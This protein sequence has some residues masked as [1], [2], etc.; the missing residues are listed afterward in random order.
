MSAPIIPFAPGADKFIPAALDSLNAD[1]PTKAA[2][3]DVLTQVL[4]QEIPREQAATRLESLIGTSTLLRDLQQ[5][6]KSEMAIH[7][8]L[9][10]EI[11]VPGFRKQ[12][13]KWCKEEDHKL[14]AAVQQHGTD[15]WPLIASIVGGGRTRSQCSQRW[16]RGIDPKLTK[17][18][19]SREEEERL[20]AAVDAH[21]SKAWTRIAA[22]MGNRSDVQCRFR[23]RFLC[24]K[25]KEANGP[26]QPISPPM[27]VAHLMPEVI[28]IP[29]N[30]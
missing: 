9:V 26:L 25:A 18:N 16:Q 12:K 30:D 28:A 20:L 24:Q 13:S 23:Y 14:L 5:M 10:R 17:A 29:E 7:P 19:W 15:N 8:P 2:V 1:G 11:S 4:R 21:G 22:D 6:R 27:A 3:A